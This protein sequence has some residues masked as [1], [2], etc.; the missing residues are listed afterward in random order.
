MARCS[1]ARTSLNGRPARDQRANSN[2]G[3]PVSTSVRR[4]GGAGAAG[5]PSGETAVFSS[6]SPR[7][8]VIST[9]FGPA[10]TRSRSVRA[11]TAIPCGEGSS[12]NSG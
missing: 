4:S 2:S 7:P 9:A 10:L 1:S 5:V 3:G 6:S 8:V 12:E 11:P